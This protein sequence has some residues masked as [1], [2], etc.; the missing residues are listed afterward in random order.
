MTTVRFRWTT[1]G[2][3]THV[4]AYSPVWAATTGGPLHVTPAERPDPG[5]DRVGDRHVTGG[6]AWCSLVH[7]PIVRAE[8]L[9]ARS[10]VDLLPVHM[11]TD[12]TRSPPAVV[13][14]STRAGV[15]RGRSSASRRPPSP[16]TSM[17]RWP[18]RPPKRDPRSETSSSAIAD[19]A[20]RLA[21]VGLRRLVG[22]T[23]HRSRI[24]SREAPHRG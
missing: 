6:S 11:V 17:S 14:A 22:V 15:V 24:R 4:H 19:A 9:T 1:G 3:C 12:L 16:E 18:R 8:K 2:G 7:P 21:A 13:A 23:F 20:V 10:K 5:G